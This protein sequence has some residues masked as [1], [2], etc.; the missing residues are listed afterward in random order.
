M[1]LNGMTAAAY[2]RKSRAEESMSAT[3]VLARHRETLERYAADNGIRIAETYP[4]VA[5]GESLYARPKMLKL[6]EDVEAGKYDCVLCMDMDRLSRGSMRDQGLILDAFKASGTLIVTPEKVYD[7][8]DEADEEYAE[9][10]TF[11]S[12]REYKIINKRLRRGLRQ[13]IEDG[14]YI[15]NAPYGYRRAFAGRKPTLEIVE[16]E[17]RFVRMMFE[18]YAA[19]YGC[20]SIAR[21]VNALGARPRRAAEFSRGSVKKILDNPAYI[22]KVVWN[23]KSRVGGNGKRVAV[24]NPK[25]KWLIADGLHPAIVDRELWD[26]A[27]SVAEGRYYPSKNDGTVK[28]P[29]SGLVLCENCGGHMQRLP[30]SKGGPYLACTRR[31]CCASAKYE[32]A[33]KRVL[34]ALTETLKE[35]SLDLSRTQSGPDAAQETALKAARAELAEAERAKSRLYDLAEAG[36]YSAAE[37]RERMDKAKARIAAL[38][39][40]EAEARAA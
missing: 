2:L 21:Q 32:L 19:G 33:E 26:K 24:R 25:E 12:R 29:L 15:A 35:L 14:C 18:L 7:L 37:F 38:A 30:F 9:L 16:P 22:G 10:K 31:G 13:S 11:L 23:Q 6:L 34:S 1:N 39:R 8:T 17:A 5:S 20:V 4:E 36:A 27:R 28:S 3:E 40:G